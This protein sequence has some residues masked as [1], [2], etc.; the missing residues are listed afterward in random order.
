MAV[1]PTTIDIAEELIDA[2]AAQDFE[3]AE[4]CFAPDVD[5][6]AVVPGTGSFRERAGAAETASQL[7]LWFGDSDPLEL[8]EHSV[9]PVVDKLRLSYRFAAF[10][11]NRWH[12]VEQHAYAVIGERGIE[13]LDL[14]CSGFRPVPERPSAR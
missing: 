10:E 4:R 9:E 1:A 13:K 14:M 5:F 12:V 6:H 7:R 2:L 11:D 3:R 8:L